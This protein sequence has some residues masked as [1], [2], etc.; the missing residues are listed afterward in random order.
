M[1]GC[2]LGFQSVKDKRVV[3]CI[4][5][6]CSI[7]STVKLGLDCPFYNSIDGRE[8]EDFIVIAT[9]GMSVAEVRRVV[10]DDI[11]LRID[12]V[13]PFAEGD[14]GREFD[15]A[16]AAGVGHRAGFCQAWC[17]IGIDIDAPMTP[18]PL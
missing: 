8:F 12:T 4:N 17:L 7:L 16:N 10:Y 1:L 5:D 6:A 18:Q 2:R 13:H 11:K 15:K 3:Q 9:D 14:R